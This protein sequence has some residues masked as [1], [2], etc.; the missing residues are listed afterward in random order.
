MTYADPTLIRETL[1]DLRDHVHAM[2]T[3]WRPPVDPE[4]PRRLKPTPGPSAPVR[5][6]VIDVEVA[7]RTELVG[8]ALESLPGEVPCSWSVGG[9]MDMVIQTQT[10]LRVT[11][12]RCLRL[13]ELSEDAARI[14]GIVDDVA[15]DEAARFAELR[16]RTVGVGDWSGGIREAARLATAAGYPVSAPTL[17]RWAAASVIPSE[18]TADG[19]PELRLSDVLNEVAHRRGW[20]DEP[21]DSDTE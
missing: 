17:S 4:M 9:V 19:V 2:R 3:P 15:Q 5:S 11:Q 20:H 8:L 18:T 12:D 21:D 13:R 14:A 10:P 16:R 7:V 1:L 6:A